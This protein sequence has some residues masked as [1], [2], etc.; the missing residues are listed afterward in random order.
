MSYNAGLPVKFYGVS[1]VTATPTSRHPQLGEE[2]YDAD[3]NKYVWAY[4]A[5]NSEIGKGFGCVLQ[6]GVSTAYSMTLSAATSAD[7]VVGVV[8]HTSIP[9]ANYGFLLTR[10]VGVAEM[11]ATSGSVASRGLVEIGANGVWVPVSNTTG[12]KAAAV[13]QALEAIVSSA[14]GSAFFSIY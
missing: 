2:T 11:G 8:K 7:L 6:S 4:N 9:T 3:G 12:N 13:G 10:G 5:G 14:S 1:H